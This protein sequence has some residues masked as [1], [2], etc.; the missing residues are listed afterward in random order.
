M[1]TL[2]AAIPLY[3]GGR[4]QRDARFAVLSDLHFYDPRLG[5]SG[6]AFE[7]Y[8][9]QDPKLLKESEAILD[10]AIT[11]IV[12]Q[13]VQF[14]LVAGDLTKDGELLDHVRV[15]QQLRRLEQRGIQ[16]FVIP[17]NHDINNP[18]AFA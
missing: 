17:G 18:D 10:A 6:Q 11:N 12:Q 9:N 15:A 8:L 2:A 5:T 3:A 1:A 14:V 16:V 7:D 4:P 13:H